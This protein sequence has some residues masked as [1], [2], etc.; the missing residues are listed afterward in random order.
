MR[1]T[2]KLTCLSEALSPLTHM[3]RTEGNEALV[4]R[5]PLMTPDGLRWVPYLSGNA[6]RH[7]L[8]R[9]PLARHLV[10]ML[11]LAGKLSLPQLNFLFHGGNLTEG[12]G[13]EVTSQIADAQRLFPMLRLLGGSLP[14]QILAGSLQVWRGTLVCRENERALAAMLP[15]GFDIPAGL[16]PAEWFVEGYQYT[17]GDAAKGERN[18]MADGEPA[19]DSNLMIFAGQQVVR[20]ACFVHGFTLSDVSRVELGA[21]ALG[22]RRWLA[23]DATIGGQ[24]ARGHGRLALAVIGGDAA[25]LADAESSYLAHVEANADEC[26]AWLDAAFRKKDDAGKPKKGG[27]KPKGADTPLEAAASE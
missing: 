15:E 2:Y 16:R 20:H 21:M 13:R 23:G 17:R 22:L 9:E 24:S 5:E 18:L 8:V 12:G 19:G 11:G 6:I 7:R 14:A 26:R 3:M 4:A 1:Q 27:R 25:D 10:A